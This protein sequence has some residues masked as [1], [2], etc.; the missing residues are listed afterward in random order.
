M[1]RF[2]IA[3]YTAQ[4]HNSETLRPAVSHEPNAVEQGESL[5]FRKPHF[6][7]TSGSL[8]AVERV[9]CTL[10]V[11]GTCCTPEHSIRIEQAL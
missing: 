7:A 5:I 4:N 10:R 6:D 11:R 3:F 8:S 9:V 2:K 1:M